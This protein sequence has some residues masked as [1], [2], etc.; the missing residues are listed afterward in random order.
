MY[1]IWGIQIIH[2]LRVYEENFEKRVS[3]LCV[4]D[5]ISNLTEG[6]SH[7]SWFCCTVD[8]REDNS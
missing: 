6:K 7:I 4:C 3:L 1:L 8:L 2:C 5:S